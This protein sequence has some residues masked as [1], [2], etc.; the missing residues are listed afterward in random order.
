MYTLTFVTGNANKLREV[1]AI[2]CGGNDNAVVGNW[3]ITNKAVDLDEVQGSVEEVT[4]HKAEQAAS[5][6]GG[7]VLVED[8][9][10]CF[11]ALGGLPGPYIKWFVEKVGLDGINKML[12]GFSDRHANAV[13]T[14]GF[15]AGPGSKVELFQGIT[16]GEIVPQRGGTG[17]GWDAIFQPEGFD[18]TYAEMAGPDKNLISQRSKALA[19]VKEYLEK[20]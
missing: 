6:I 7:P 1:R 13:T 14:F 3:S 12:D 20:V 5:L 17:F 8:T 2:L 18:R 10:L 11:E 19:K 16:T 9:C 15:C 4:R